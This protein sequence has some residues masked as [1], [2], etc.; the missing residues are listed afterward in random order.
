MADDRDIERAIVGLLAGRSADA[1]IC[2]SDV[3]RA[4]SDDA[5][6]GLMERVRHVAATL[7]AD[8][9]VRVTQGDVEVRGSV[10]QARGPVRLRR[11]PAFQPPFD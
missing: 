10:A 1:S 8:G 5:W 2:P 7:A 3:A 11:G 9:Q 6:R 4:L